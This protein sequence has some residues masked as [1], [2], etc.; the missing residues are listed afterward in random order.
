MGARNILLNHFSQRYPKLPKLNTFSNHNK[1]STTGHQDISISFDLMSVRLG[2]MW[3]M[4]YY[5]DAMELLF[6]PEEEAEEEG[7]GVESAVRGDVNPTLDK[8]GKGKTKA[9]EEKNKG[10]GKAKMQKNGKGVMSSGGTMVSESG[11]KQ[12]YQAGST[13]KELEQDITTKR[14]VSPS[15]ADSESKRVKSDQAEMLDKNYTSL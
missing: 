6:P 11:A 3:R 2:E 15:S 4:K 1:P 9:K 14:G 13:D 8:N 5:H 10:K 12:S 7:D